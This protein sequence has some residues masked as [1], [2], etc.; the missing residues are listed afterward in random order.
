MRSDLRALSPVTL[1][2]QLRAR[3]FHL[4]ESDGRVVVYRRGDHELDV[5]LRSDF[6]DYSRRVEEL[7]GILAVLEGIPT[8]D[9]VASL[10]EAEP[11]TAP[12]PV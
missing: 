10:L 3:G 8:N 6:A 1:Q 5:P 4:Q 12:L 2:E 7:I 9:L 11:D